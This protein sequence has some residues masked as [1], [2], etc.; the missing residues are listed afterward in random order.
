MKNTLM[1]QSQL[2]IPLMTFLPIV[3]NVYSLKNQVFK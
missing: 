2:Q 3:E 1:I